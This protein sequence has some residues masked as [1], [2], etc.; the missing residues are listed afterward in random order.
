[1]K[2]DLF[3]RVVDNFGDA[4]VSARLARQLANEE[5]C[6]VRLWIDD[7]TCLAKL[8]P[9]LDAGVASQRY[10]GIEIRRWDAAARFEPDADVFI[11]AFGCG[12]PEGFPEAMAR[13]GR[14]PLWINLE[15]L[16]AEDFA[17]E[18]HALPS[19]QPKLPLTRHF[20]FPGFAPGTGGLPRERDLGARRKAFQG[21][22][23]AGVTFL[24][25]LGV[26]RRH[27][28]MVVSMFCYDNPALA[29][30]A[31]LWE[32]GES[33]IHCLV[34]AGSRERV[35]QTFGLRG[36]VGEIVRRG[37]LAVQT[38][39][40][41]AQ[42]DYDHLLWSCD[43]NFVRG[44]DSFVRAQWA[45]RPFVWQPY[46]QEADAHLDKLRAFLKLYLYGLD[47]A[48]QFAVQ[49]MFE[50]WNGVGKI[51][52]AWPAFADALPQ[53]A[54]HATAWENRMVSLGSLAANLAQFCK[55]AVKLQ[56]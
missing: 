2:I 35:L 36:N 53:I 22:T 39:P 51:D 17:A 16:T 46:N 54:T 29:A 27:D 14:P 30:L 19:P 32:A 40:F 28:A 3:C 12:L 5:G 33:P 56:V 4:G 55:N 38:I 47:P 11:D 7:V 20:F 50:A 15:Y 21:N 41:V 26:V 49:R 37:A 18:C 25:S 24:E 6:E 8:W 31:G 44:E 13:Q 10:A 48:S 1:M 52:E 34:P 42:D 23:S 43:L 9:A 45:D